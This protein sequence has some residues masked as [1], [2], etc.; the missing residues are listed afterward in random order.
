MGDPV[1]GRFAQTPS[2]YLHI[3]NAFTALLA[4]LQVRQQG[5]EFVLRIEDLDERRLN[6]E[7]VSAILEDL[8]WLGLDWDEGPDVGGRHG[9]YRQKDRIEQ[10]QHTF[11]TLKKQGLVYPCFC[12]RKELR[13]AAS[14]PHGLASEGPVYRG[15]C[16]LLSSAEQLRRMRQKQPA[17]RFVVPN[18]PVEFTDL[19][20]GHQQFGTAFGGDFIVYRAD[21]VFSYQLAVVVDDAEMGITQVLRGD[22]LIDSTARQIYLYEA[23]GLVQ[24]SFA[25]V[26]LIYSADGERFAKRNGSMTLRSLR[27]KGVTAEQ[28]TGYLGWFAGLLDRPEP[29]RPADLTEMFD[30]RRI[31]RSKVLLPQDW[32]DTLTG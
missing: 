20:A 6:P 19:V 26:P 28:I 17:W 21:A 4:W 3:G 5:G 9:A 32:M 14:A 8:S 2:G 25:H 30:L 22:D 11:D 18:R 7:Y 12:S 15:T 16:R 1:R 23:L 27:S 29:L 24:P 13:E 31:A 10:Y